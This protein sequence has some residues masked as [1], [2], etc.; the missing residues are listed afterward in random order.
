MTDSQNA[1]E[2]ENAGEGA[3]QK[4]EQ[5]KSFTQAEVDAIIRDRLK[6]QERTKFGD[7]QELKT[8][9][10]GA[11]TLEERLG[12]L[13]QELSTTKAE[14]LRSSIAARF[15]ISTQKGK[16][17]EPSDAD[18]FLTGTDESTL[19]AQAQRLAA[20]QADSKKQGNVAPK[21]GETKTSGSG[22]TELREFARELFSRA[23]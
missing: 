21:E 2:A 1:Q 9:A 7:Y 13:E 6:Q 3:E 5:G 15:G 12:S 10:E 14:A 11:K 22:D 16:D 18:L 19:T 23:D 20:R 8:K 17:G 4:Q